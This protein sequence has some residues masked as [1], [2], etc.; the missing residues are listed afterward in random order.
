MTNQ[1]ELTGRVALVTGAARNIGRAIAVGLA[2][3]G[4]NVVVHARSSAAA[5]EETA[6]LCLAAA[7][8][9]QAVV[10]LADLTKPEDVKAMMAAI[11][12]RFGKLD[13]LVHSAAERADAPFESISYEDWRRIVAS[14]LDS[15]F[16]CDQ[17]A[18]PLLRKSD[19]ASILHIGGVAGH[20]GVRHRPHVSAA[21]A[22]I[23]G[24]TR[25]LA[26]EFAPEGITVNCLSPGYMETARK[27]HLPEH[28]RERPVPLGRPGQPTELADMARFLVGPSGRFVTG[29]VIHFN[30]GWHMA[31]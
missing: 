6:A 11:E 4:A 30:G 8:D 17:A 22:G 18:M 27:G 15:A 14:I 10:M 19:A 23:A 2:Q 3:G 9:A 29:Q 28:F 13:I 16:L 31:G 24:L 21:K 5:A 26:A 1:G 7:P 12:T 20:A 25:A